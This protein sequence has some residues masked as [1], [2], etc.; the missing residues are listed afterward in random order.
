MTVLHRVPGITELL[1][2]VSKNMTTAR[3]NAGFMLAFFCPSSSTIMLNYNKTMTYIKRVSGY[4][5]ICYFPTLPLLAET[6]VDASIKALRFDYEEFDQS[7]TSL[8][9]ETGFIPGISL[10]ISKTKGELT[11]LIS[12]ELY[13]G[14]VNYD[15]QT[16]SGTPHLTNTDETL[17]RV[18]YKLNWSPENNNSSIY[19]KVAWQQWDR[20]I[21][22]A[23]N[24]SGLFEQY[25]WWAFELGFLA[26]LFESNSDKWQFEFGVSKI[27]NGT[28]NIDLN[29]QGFGQPE[30]ELGDG[31]GV[32]V[33]LIYQHKLS[34]RNKIGLSLLHQRWTFGRSNTQT[35]SN[36][37][38]SF[39]IVE[40][41]SVSNHSII[42]FNYGHY[43]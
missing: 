29:Q 34:D 4:F 14:Q 26:T 39:D 15:G 30:L 41:R 32:S 35:I 7:G 2:V 18:L 28:I 12:V 33:A 21:L 31:N 11:S 20:N 8:N 37:T 25:Q 16:Q 22:P 43:F 24:I 9:R 38:L 42:S 1:P 36:G 17:H 13:D 3:K 6:T 10:Y 27:N 23:N 40:P 5:F 19:G